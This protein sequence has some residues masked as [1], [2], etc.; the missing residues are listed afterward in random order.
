MKTHKEIIE[1]VLNKDKIIFNIKKVEKV[2]KSALQLRDEDFLKE[3][4]KEFESFRKSWKVTDIPSVAQERYD[5][6]MW[7]NNY[8]MEKLKSRMKGEKLK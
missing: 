5:F 1:S 4:D 3:I 8:L 6:A 2:I 7:F